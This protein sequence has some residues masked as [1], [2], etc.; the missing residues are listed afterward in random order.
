VRTW[1][2]TTLMLPGDAPRRWKNIFTSEVI[3]KRRSGLALAD[4]FHACPVAVL[5]S[6]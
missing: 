6:E 2:S 3:T 4:V 5:V 1:K